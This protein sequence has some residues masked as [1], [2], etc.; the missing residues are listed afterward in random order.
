M[1]ALPRTFPRSTVCP[2]GPTEQSD[3]VGQRE[4]FAEETAAKA[5]DDVNQQYRRADTI[6]P[7]S[8]NGNTPDEDTSVGGTR[9]G[10]PGDTQSPRAMPRSG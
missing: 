3:E 6:D 7:D 5:R 8:Q 1:T 9:R 2:A 10:A 4:A